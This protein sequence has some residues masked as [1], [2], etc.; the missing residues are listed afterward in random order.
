MT[1][2]AY[3][4]LSLETLSP[5]TIVESNNVKFFEN[6]FSFKKTSEIVGADT[7]DSKKR[8]R[9]TETT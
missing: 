5:H 1:S 8:S 6:I 4:F 3:R 2:K 7:S 9:T